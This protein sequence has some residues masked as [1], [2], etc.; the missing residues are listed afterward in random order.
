MAVKEAIVISRHQSFPSTSFEKTSGAA[1]LHVGS[2]CVATD[3]RPVSLAVAKEDQVTVGRSHAF[4]SW[5][6]PTEK[7]ETP[8]PLSTGSWCT[9]PLHGR[10]GLPN[11][12][13]KADG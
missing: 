5:M 8:V 13:G 9:V 4:E 1:Q 7:G 6:D 11:Q 10:I 12:G 3:D 2:T